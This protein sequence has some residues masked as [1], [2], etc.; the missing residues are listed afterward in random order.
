[1]LEKHGF[2]CWLWALGS[3]AMKEQALDLTEAKQA[4]EFSQKKKKKAWKDQKTRLVE[5][6]DTTTG[7]L[8]LAMAPRG[9]SHGQGAGGR[10]TG[11]LIRGLG[12]DVWMQYCW[13][14]LQDRGGYGRDC[15]VSRDERLQSE[16]TSGGLWMNPIAKKSLWVLHLLMAFPISTLLTFTLESCSKALIRPQLLTLIFSENMCS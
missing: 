12:T 15:R 13:G 14:L 8:L 3:K 9:K 6:F 11:E 5:K 1:M 4:K 2:C 16:K 7:T 10:C